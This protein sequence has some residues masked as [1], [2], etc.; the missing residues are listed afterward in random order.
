MAFISAQKTAHKHNSKEDVPLVEFICILY[1]IY[2]HAM[3][4]LQ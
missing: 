1:K 3:Q 2:P 4:E